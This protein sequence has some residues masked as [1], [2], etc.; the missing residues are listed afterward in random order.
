[1]SRPRLCRELRVDQ[2]DLI[3]LRALGS[4]DDIELDRIAFFEALVPVKLDGAVVD[5]DVCGAIFTAQEAVALGVVEPLNRS[6]I[7]SHV[8]LTPAPSACGLAGI[9]KDE[10]GD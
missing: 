10:D 6:L 8:S 5:E 9:S 7:L 4:L 3:G 1:M 2:N